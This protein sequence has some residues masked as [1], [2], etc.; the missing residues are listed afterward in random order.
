MELDRVNV[1]VLDGVAR[2]HD[3]RLLEAGDGPKHLQLDVDGEAWKARWGSPPTVSRP[4]GSMN[5][6]CRSFSGKRTTLSSMEG[7]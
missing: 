7:Q 5:V 1:V 4:S 3:L 2:P 6:W